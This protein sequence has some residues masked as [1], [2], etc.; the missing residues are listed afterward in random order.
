M[1][2]LCELK[3]LQHDMDQ[4]VANLTFEQ[5]IIDEQSLFSSMAVDPSLISTDSLDMD[6]LRARCETN[7][8]DYKLTFEDS[9]QWTQSGLFSS[10]SKNT[11][12]TSDCSSS[13]NAM[14]TWARLRTDNQDNKRF[15]V[16]TN[17][18]P[19]LND[20]ENAM[21]PTEHNITTS[22]QRPSSLFVSLKFKCRI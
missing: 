3:L 2:E 6:Q 15:D 17:S 12:G 5:S 21:S 20:G 9:G 4:H 10:P 11:T 16:K 19:L 8:N 13:N 7:K 14:T 1:V 22:Q 18:L